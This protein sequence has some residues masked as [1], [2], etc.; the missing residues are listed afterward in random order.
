MCGC[1]KLLVRVSVWYVG[2]F[3]FVVSCLCVCVYRGREGVSEKGKVGDGGKEGDGWSVSGTSQKFD[4][5]SQI[6]NGV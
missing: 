4:F 2:V 3:V 6:L 1:A 5:I